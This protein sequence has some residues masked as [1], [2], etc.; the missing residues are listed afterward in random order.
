MATRFRQITEA[1]RRRFIKAASYLEA[2]IDIVR[3]MVVESLLVEGY[4]I[5]APVYAE[6]D[7]MVAPLTT[8]TVSL[9]LHELAAA[10]TLMSLV[11]L[12][13]VSETVYAPV[14][15]NTPIAMS[16]AAIVSE[17]VSTYAPVYEEVTGLILGLTTETENLYAP[18]YFEWDINFNQSPGL[19]TI[20]ETVY[21]PTADSK[22]QMSIA[23]V[24]TE[25]ETI[26]TP[27]LE[28]PSTNPVAYIYYLTAPGTDGAVRRVTGDGVTDTE[29]VASIETATGEDSDVNNA[30]TFFTEAS[31]LVISTD[32]TGANGWTFD[33]DGSNFVD[34]YNALAGEISIIYRLDY[35]DGWIGSGSNTE[36]IYTNDVSAYENG[37]RISNIGG[38][39]PYAVAVDATNNNLYWTVTGETT[40]NTGTLGVNGKSSLFDVGIGTQPAAMCIDPD[41]VNADL[42][43]GRLWVWETVNNELLVYNL[44]GSLLNTIT[45][46]ATYTGF[47][48]SCLRHDKYNNTVYIHRSDT[49][50]IWTIS[51]IEGAT[52][53][54]AS[55]LC[56]LNANATDEF[57]LVMTNNLT[58]TLPAI[59]AIPDKVLHL[60]A[61]IAYTT[62]DIQATDGQ[63][64]VKWPDQ[65]GN[66]NDAVNT[67][68]GQYPL[69]RASVAAV[70]SLPAVDFDGVNDYLQIP[71]GTVTEVHTVV[72]ALVA[73][74]GSNGYFLFC[75]V[76]GTSNPMGL[77]DAGDLDYFDSSSTIDGI[78][79]SKAVGQVI[80]Y[81][82]ATDQSFV[83]SVS[84]Q[85]PQGQKTN[86]VGTPTAAGMNSPQTIGARANVTLPA[87]SLPWEGQ[88]AEILIW[89][90]EL[91]RIELLSVR[92]EL[93]TKY[94]I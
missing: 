38:D 62:G 48:I 11:A 26:Y 43:V 37:L 23:A 51:G 39:T 57:A 28:S 89:N 83:T 75:G 92:Q 67:N 84:S 49:N 73:D 19:I 40:I 68:A 5:Y 58:P 10:P 52:A 6:G 21:A 4:T 22:V 25:T 15:A 70:N 45:L 65:S 64:I 3:Q 30:I 88:I 79:F 66:S 63:I 86:L 59:S 35:A 12:Q 76:N 8:E 72:M 1:R 44:A 78:S 24:V 36:D 82:V 85:F 20:P 53:G 93:E 9:Y 90:R 56:T 50:E 55:S 41:I 87:T 33:L 32:V 47:E 74:T 27:L 29:V 54:L 80:Q 16:L 42:S 13:F 81:R 60:D 2:E 18:T 91:T 17:T 77:R 7:L 94:A 71:D 14:Y 34:T 31:K 61:S 69:W 46:G